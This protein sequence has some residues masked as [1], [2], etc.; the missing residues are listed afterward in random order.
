MVQTARQEAVVLRGY[1]VVSFLT[2]VNL[3]PSTAQ[4]NDKRQS[5]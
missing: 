1:V 3:L 2:Q 4:N 5:H